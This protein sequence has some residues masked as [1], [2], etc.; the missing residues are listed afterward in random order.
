LLFA[1]ERQRAHLLAE[2]RRLLAAG[3]T[4]EGLYQAGQAEATRAGPDSRQLQALACLL[5]RDFAGAWRHYQNA[6]ER[7]A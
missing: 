6:G 1:L 3:Q 4:A 5:Q 7:G 2:A